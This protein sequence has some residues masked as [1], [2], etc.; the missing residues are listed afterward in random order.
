MPL[1]TLRFSLPRF[2]LFHITFALLPH[3]FQLHRKQPGN[4]P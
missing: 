2:D 4:T 3:C 1:L